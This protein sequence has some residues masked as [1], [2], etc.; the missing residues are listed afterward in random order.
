MLVW[1]DTETGSEMRN[2]VY[3]ER[4]SRKHQWGSEWPIKGGTHTEGVLSAPRT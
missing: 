1:A 3:L 4:N 2:G